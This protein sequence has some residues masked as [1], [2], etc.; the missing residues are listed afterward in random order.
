[1]SR[2]CIECGNPH[3]MV[4]ENS[5]TGEVIERLEKCASCLLKLRWIEPEKIVLEEDDP[6]KKKRD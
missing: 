3:D 6:H 5:R 2:P 1:M 4:V